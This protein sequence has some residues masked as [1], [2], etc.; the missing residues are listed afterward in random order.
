MHQVDNHGIFDFEQLAFRNYFLQDCEFSDH[1]FSVDRSS[2]KRYTLSSGH[3]RGITAVGHGY[4]AEPRP[5]P[6]QLV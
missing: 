4:P 1:C 2:L 3:C 5:G 6:S